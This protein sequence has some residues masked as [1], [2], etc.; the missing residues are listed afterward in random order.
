MRNLA[1]ST[2][3]ILFFSLPPVAMALWPHDGAA[4]VVVATPGAA[5]VVGQA[6]GAVLA[7]SDGDASA[8]TRSATAEPGFLGRLR[9]AGARLV[10]AAP[11]D[12][13][14]LATPTDPVASLSRREPA[15]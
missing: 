3:V 8:I 2:A 12:L 14:C 1:V 4:V 7:L 11:D 13:A 10:L 6:G 15:R 5:A 9:S